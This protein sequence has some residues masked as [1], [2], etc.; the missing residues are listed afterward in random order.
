MY[1]AALHRRG[2]SW[3]FTSYLPP[4]AAAGRATRAAAPGGRASSVVFSSPCQHACAPSPS[5]HVGGAVDE[6]LHAA[7]VVQGRMLRHAGTSTRISRGRLR[8][9]RRPA[10]R[11]QPAGQQGRQALIH[12]HRPETSA[13]VR[14]GA[15]ARFGDPSLSSCPTGPPPRSRRR[16][17]GPG[18]HDPVWWRRTTTPS[19]ADLGDPPRIPSLPARTQSGKVP[20]ALRTTSAQA[21]KDPDHLRCSGQ[22]GV[23]PYRTAMSSAVIFH[24]P[25]PRSVR[26]V[27]QGSLRSRAEGPCRRR[28]A[29]RRTRAFPAIRCVRRTQVPTVEG[30]EDAS[31]VAAIHQPRDRE[32]VTRN[33]RRRQ[34]GHAAPGRRHVSDGLRKEVEHDLQGVRPHRST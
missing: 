30:G 24:D 11:R 12:V 1:A 21:A 22:P 20:L 13:I 16:L 27:M 2:R 19:K 34:E 26:M 6:A 28:N 32:P 31:S 33:L 5:I 10:K 18:A 7:R 15:R 3:L 4:I 14:M 23:G 29:C 17:P 9:N 8:A 25:A